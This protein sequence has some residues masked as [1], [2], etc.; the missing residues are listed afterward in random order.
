ML[1]MCESESEGHVTS[2]RPVKPLPPSLLP[3]VPQSRPQGRL[4]NGPSR[5]LFSYTPQMKSL[6]SSLFLPGGRHLCRLPSSF[7]W[8]KTSDRLGHEQCSFLSCWATE[9]LGLFVTTG[10]LTWM[11]QGDGCECYYEKWTETETS[12]DKKNTC[13]RKACSSAHL[14]TDLWFNLSQAV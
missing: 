8:V 13:N 3:P 1:E 6:T 5:S 11:Q 14:E 2:G 10:S 12:N 9:S 7:I 4:F